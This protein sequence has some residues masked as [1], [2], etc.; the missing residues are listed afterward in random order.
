M[1]IGHKILMVLSGGLLVVLLESL[2]LLIERVFNP[3]TR[4]G[5]GMGFTAVL[6]FIIPLFYGLYGI[7]LSTILVVVNSFAFVNS[8]VF[9]IVISLVFSLWMCWGNIISAQEI[10]NRPN[11]FDR[12]YFVSDVFQ[13]CADF[14]IFPAVCVSIWFLKE[15][16]FNHRVQ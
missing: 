8:I 9:S 16:Y 7:L 13:I 1:Q 11:Y 15:K 4:N 3:S 14:I 5:F 2:A 10:Y 6:I 12:E